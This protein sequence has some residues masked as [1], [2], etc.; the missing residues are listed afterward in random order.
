[1]TTSAAPDVLTVLADRRR[2]GQI[3]ANLA[4]NALRHTPEGGLIAVRAVPGDRVAWVTVEDTGEGIPSER[5][6]HVFERF[7]RGDDARDRAS[8]GAGLGLAIVRELVEAMGGSVAVESALGQ[9]T[10]FSFSV[11]LT[12][13]VQTANPSNH[14]REVFADA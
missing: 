9:G 7:Y 3:L 6:P 4:R 14:G 13:T 11:P 12:A 2:V 10:R 5:L 1:M 8:G